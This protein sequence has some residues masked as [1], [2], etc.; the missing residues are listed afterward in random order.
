MVQN[1]KSNEGFTIIE[2]LI[3]LAIAGLIMM[4]VFLAVPSLQRN[5]RNTQRRNDVSSAL[6]A[7]QE[8]S[9]NVNGALPTTAS[10]VYGNIT[11]AYY[12]ATNAAIFLSPNP[13]TFTPTVVADTT[14]ATASNIN[15]NSFTIV[16]GWRC[17]SAN[18]VQKA[19][20]RSVAILYAVERQGSNTGTLVC[21]GS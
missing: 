20:T 1:K 16:T 17:S 3:V 13:N 18:T 19:S 6:G 11:P 14:T 12:A 8:Y 4:V 5:S 2:V 9:S 15:T 21:Q 10:Q 7:I